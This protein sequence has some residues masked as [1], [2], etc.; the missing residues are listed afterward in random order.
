[1]AVSTSIIL[2]QTRLSLPIRKF[3]TLR[4][5]LPLFDL[6]AL[7][8]A[9]VMDSRNRSSKDCRL[10]VGYVLAHESRVGYSVLWGLKFYRV[11]VQFSTSECVRLCTEYRE[12][13]I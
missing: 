2:V 1:M 11:F 8:G 10:R 9:W 5:S 6:V 3:Q 7:D 12:V 4:L 13:Y